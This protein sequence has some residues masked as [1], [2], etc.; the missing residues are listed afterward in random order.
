MQG[1]LDWYEQ[2]PVDLIPMLKSNKDVVI[3]N[4][5]LGLFLLMRFNQLQPPFDNPAIRRAV[6]AAVN[7][8][9]YMEAVVGDKAFYSGAKTFFTPGSPMSSGAGGAAAMP[10]NL[11]KAKAMLKEAGY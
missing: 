9:D 8:T 2:P 10:G 1:E 3:E 5:P 4:V 6:M 11:E 7:Q